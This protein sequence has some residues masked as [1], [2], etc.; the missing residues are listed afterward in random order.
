MV[1]VG[2]LHR[3]STLLRRVC[4]LLV[5]AFTASTLPAQTVSFLSA[6]SIAAN[7][8][9]S[10]QSVA[11]DSAGTLYV[12]D[13][14]NDQ[15]VKVAP[16]GTK[17][18]LKTG[19]LT[20]STPSGV[21]VDAAGDVFIADTYNSRIVKVAADGSTS[22]LNPGGFQLDFPTGIAADSTGNVYVVSNVYSGSSQACQIL[23]LSASGNASLAQSGN[24]VLNYCTDV[25]V[26]GQGNLYIIDYQPDSANEGR[27]VE[28]STNGSASVADMNGLNLDAP[29]G[30]AVDAEG[31][32]YIADTYN[33]HVI[34]IPAGGK[35]Y[36]V[37][38]GE[39]EE[40]YASNVAAA[41]NGVI[42]IL[43]DLFQ[44]NVD[45]LMKTQLQTADAGGANVCPAGQSSPAPCSRTLMLNYSFG[46]S[47]DLEIP[48]FSNPEFSVKTSTC[49]GSF[50]SGDICQITV[51]FA[52]SSPGARMGAIEL[53]D[54]NDGNP[55]NTSYVS[56]LG[57]APSVGFLPGTVGVLNAGSQ[58]LTLPGG[59][60]VDQKGNRYI[61]DRSSNQVFEI[62]SAGAEAPISTGSLA[63]SQPNGLAL[64]G[65]NTLYIADSGHNRMVVVPASGS[66]SALNTGSVTLQQ[67][68]SVAVDGSGT[69]YVVS[70][71]DNH[72]VEVTAGGSVSLLN[73]GSIV[74]QQ[75]RGIALDAEGSIYIANTGG[76]NIVKVTASGSASVLN[77]GN[78]TLQQPEGLALDAAGTLYVADAAANHVVQIAANGA[79]SIAGTGSYTLS[80]PGAVALDSSGNLVV[81]DAG[82]SRILFIDR[83]TPPAL[84]FPQTAAGSVSS[85]QAVT[86]TNL[87]NANL[88]FPGL[89]TGANPSLSA[90]FVLDGSSS[91]PQLD[92]SAF[93]APLSPGSVC[94][95]AI[96]FAPESVGSVSGSLVVTDNTGNNANPYAA[97]SIALSGISTIPSAALT[98][99]SSLNPSVYGQP[100]T[101]QAAIT[102]AGSVP[103]GAVT[104]RDGSI[105]LGTATIGANGI[106]SIVTSLLGVGTHSITANYAGSANV[107]ASSSPV[108]AQIVNKAASTVVLSTSNA[109]PNVG[110]SI[111]FTAAT[112]STAGVPS[113]AMQFLDGSTVLGTV[114]LNA[115]GAA[116][117]TATSLTAGA[118]TIYAV[119]AGDANFFGSQT[120]LT[121]QVKAAAAL[122]LTLNTNTL[123][124]KQG[125]AGTL[126]VTLV[127]P[128]GYVGTV[129]LSCT[130]LPQI[131]T[132]SFNPGTIKANGTN[133][134]GPATLT[135]YTVAAGTETASIG[136]AQTPADHARLAGFWFLPAGIFGVLLL[137]RRRRWQAAG[138]LFALLVLLGC[139]IGVMGCGV[140]YNGIGSTSNV[141]IQ[142]ADGNGMT[143]ST[144]F[145]L[146]ITK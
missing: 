138:H 45:Q 22:V 77:T 121:E 117:F 54:A 12:A 10:A 27:V 142:A 71:G 32:L 73:T 114:L 2:P 30:L 36:I 108:F 86:L 8:F 135:V 76:S 146:Q 141:T 122:S 98:L 131:A 57:S 3:F 47:A 102:A 90:N 53:V 28:V 129:N 103:T 44:E 140:T 144:T 88:V 92:G 134:P 96:S 110:D 133:A 112:G 132:C 115:Q 143:T 61:A 85:A 80:Q 66:A 91:C 4:L 126:T 128:S 50:V 52:P 97:Q 9:N 25:A 89:T 95:L 42:Y 109:N 14:Y 65:A 83:T 15:I 33:G 18:V 55:L 67:P 21:A 16:D 84:T 118:H 37:Q 1:L 99:T 82:K 72:I 94:S 59:I 35:A 104:F 26:D 6:A 63:L 68:Q 111:T 19:S 70:T 13:T 136:H 137:W 139:A 93:S 145:T 60:A 119:Y 64:D 24:V 124:V 40:Y 29:N 127:P 5:A 49:S 48:R 20:L 43:Q 11:V 123:T 69:V 78:V 31:N 23:K 17:S 116:V 100:V 107:L 39:E 58:A 125:Q 105:A 34:A 75:P 106:A 41:G 101:L 79:A 87:G 46:V 51:N 81:A 130:G 120:T 56:G 62:T 74:L 113:G 38:T 7:G